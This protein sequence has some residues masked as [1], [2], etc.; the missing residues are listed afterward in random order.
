LNNNSKFE[1]TFKIELCQEKLKTIDKSTLWYYIINM[2]VYD[3][4]CDNEH[5]FEGWFKNSELMNK[6]LKNSQITC[7]VCNSNKVNIKPSAVGILTKRDQPEQDKPKVNSYYFYKAVKEYIDK[8]FEDVGPKFAEESLKMHW[9][10][11]DKKN[12]RGT[13]TPEEENELIEEGVS[14]FKLN[15]PKFD[16]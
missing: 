10:E 11:I 6:Q 13:A 15:L 1:Y 5:V 4:I 14:F 12:I 2:I 3:F 7:P 9:G 8:N 16:A